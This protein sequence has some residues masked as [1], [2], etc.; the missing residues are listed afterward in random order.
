MGLTVYF[1][2]N[3]SK[4]DNS[5]KVPDNTVT[6]VTYTCNLKDGTSVLEPVLE[7]YLSSPDSEPVTNQLNY[8][9]IDKFKRY[10]FV[11]DWRY[12]MG[13]WYAYLSVDVLASYKTEIGA[14]STLILRE[15][16]TEIPTVPD[17]IYPATHSWKSTSQTV[18]LGFSDFATVNNRGYVVGILNC[19]TSYDP[20]DIMLG[21]VKY[22]CTTE[23][24]IRQLC[25]YLMD[26]SFIDNYMV[27][28]S[29]GITST[30]ARDFADPLQYIVSVMA[31]P[32]QIPYPQTQQA[33]KPMI[34]PFDTTSD[35][36]IPALHELTSLIYSEYGTSSN[37]WGW[38]VPTNPN[39]T[40]GKMFL[41][42]P[43]YVQ[44]SLDIQPWGSIPLDAE[45]V[46]AATLG[47]V[48]PSIDIDLTSGYGRLALGTTWKGCDLGV[49]QALVGVPIALA[50][51]TQDIVGAATAVLDATSSGTK[52]ALQLDVAGAASD[53][54]RGAASATE[55]I[56]PNAR[57]SG[58]NG[59]VVSYT[60]INRSEL[61]LK[62]CDVQGT[63]PTDLGYAYNQVG[64][65]SSF[66]GYIQCA[67][68][69]IEIKC[70]Q[71]E[72]TKISSYMRGGFF[73][74]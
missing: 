26:T 55:K 8:A 58:T 68:G 6:K 13:V 69:D 38:T 35:G 19:P 62:Y 24:N 41:K 12:E 73:Y 29:A 71:T 59:C 18:S 61:T 39:A 63:D 2:K 43:P 14:T 15:S 49:H 27:D 67:H 60:G 7:L 5:T 46:T 22:Y 48:Y 66:G 21:A 23:G 11:R 20:N 9:W 40:T 74:E 25:S 72:K 10:Y 45:L 54:L 42:Y 64:T 4:R 47:K 52:K 57:T 32:F 16:T 3:F 50:Q 28:L 53:A 1:Y 17:T 37:T 31:F 44:Y 51:F 34:G 30:V 36:N 65:I 70:T 33:V 56:M